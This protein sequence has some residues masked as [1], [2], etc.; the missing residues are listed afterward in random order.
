VVDGDVQVSDV[1]HGVAERPKRGSHLLGEELRLF[2]GREVTAAVDL[3]KVGQLGIR[4]AG[5]RL[6][7]L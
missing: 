1:P 3:V 4:A 7:T 5:P 2:P 6:G